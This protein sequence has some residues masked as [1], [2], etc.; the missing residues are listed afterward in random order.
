MGFEFIYLKLT[1]IFF[2]TRVQKNQEFQNNH[3][4]LKT[5]NKFVGMVQLLRSLIWV[6][7]FG[8]RI[9]FFFD[10]VILAVVYLISLIHGK[11]YQ[12]SV[13]YF[14]LCSILPESNYFY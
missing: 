7:I 13:I 10:T 6:I 11:D 8:K 2:D 1:Y 3:N 9:E 5:A 4:F 12:F 14:K